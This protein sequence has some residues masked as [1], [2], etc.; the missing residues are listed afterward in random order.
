MVNIAKLP[1]K[2]PWGRIQSA[3]AGPGLFE[4]DAVSVSPFLVIE[5][6][7]DVLSLIDLSVTVELP[8]GKHD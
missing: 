2:C 4:Q 7:L 5:T 3:K 8:H 1:D 6:A